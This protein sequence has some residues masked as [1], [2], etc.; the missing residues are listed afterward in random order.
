MPVPFRGLAAPV[1]TESLRAG[2]EHSITAET[3]E[4]RWNGEPIQ[5]DEVIDMLL[6]A[7]RTDAQKARAD[8]EDEE[9]PE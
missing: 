3:N 4:P 2:D 9:A 8:A 1:S 5:M 6:K 7:R